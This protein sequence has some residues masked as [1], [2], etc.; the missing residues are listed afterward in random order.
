MYSSES[1]TSAIDK[2]P[3]YIK[4]RDQPYYYLEIENESRPFVLSAKS[5]FDLE[6]WFNAIFAQIESLKTNRAIQRN[7]QNIR[8]KE[9][10][11][12]VADQK[13]VRTLTKFNM[14]FTP[15][16]Q[17]QL[18]D[19]VGDPFIGELLPNITKY[20]LFAERKEHY[21]HAIQKAGETLSQL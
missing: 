18:L 6:E 14:I 13:K 3:S 4:N 10:E 17:P 8:L 12:A 20:L 16:I 9:Q 7:T 1:P 15:D 2:L 5:H 21:K 11:M 19:F